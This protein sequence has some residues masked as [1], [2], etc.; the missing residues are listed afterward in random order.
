M[1]SEHGDPEALPSDIEEWITDRM[2]ET[3]D[4]RETVLAHAVASYRLLTEDEDNSLEELLSE[5]ESRIGTLESEMEAER[6]DRL[7]AELNEHVEDLRSRIVDVI[8]EA[9]KRAPANHSHEDLDARLSTIEDEYDGIHEQ[10]E[11]ITEIR[12]TATE[13]EAEIAELESMVESESSSLSKS[14]ERVESKAN[15]LAKTAI[16]LRDRISRI[17]SH[18]ANQAALAELL[19]TAAHAD[20]EKARCKNC[21]ETINLS[22][23]AEPACPHCRSVFNDI[24]PSSIFFKSAWLTVAD[25]PAL[26]AGSTMEAPLDAGETTAHTESNET[27]RDE[28]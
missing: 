7:E 5:L 1:A 15:R 3:G 26:E 25:Q 9:R 4:N 20:I 12:Q 13:L 6:V 19:E 8:K 10:D 18:V 2:E 24:E 28:E 16:K 11:T 21:R 23:L 14:V 27:Q 22:I 17:E